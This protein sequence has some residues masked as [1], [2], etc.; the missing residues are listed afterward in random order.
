MASYLGRKD[1]ISFPTLG[2]YRLKAFY[3][4]KPL[5]HKFGAIL[6]QWVLQW[7]F[8][9]FHLLTLGRS[10]KPHP[11]QADFAARIHLEQTLREGFH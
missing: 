5:L 11:F 7:A 10:P 3:W 4:A 6:G 2:Q 9:T 8:F 1:R